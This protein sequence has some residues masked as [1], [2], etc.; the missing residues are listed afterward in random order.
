MKR[1]AVLKSFLAR[2][3]IYSTAHFR[4]RHE[5]QARANL[6]LAIKS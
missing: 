5:T 3:H 6:A 1:K 4:Q 2:P